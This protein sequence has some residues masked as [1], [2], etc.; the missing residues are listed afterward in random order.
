MFSTKQPVE[1]PNDSSMDLK[2]KR[3][4]WAHE[5]PVFL[6]SFFCRLSRKNNNLGNL[7]FAQNR[8]PWASFGGVLTQFCTGEYSPG[9]AFRELFLRMRVQDLRRL[10]P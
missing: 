9:N 2:G 6:L 3:L 1:R 5:S 7:L 10:L 8:S 4:P